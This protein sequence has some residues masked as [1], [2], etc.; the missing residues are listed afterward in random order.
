VLPCV[1]VEAVEHADAG[2]ECGGRKQ[3]ELEP[4]CASYGGDEDSGGKEDAYGKLFGEAAGE[5][6]GQRARVD[7]EHPGGEERC[8]QSVK[9]KGSRIDAVQKIDKSQSAEGD[10]GE[11]AVAVLVMEAVAGFE[12][13]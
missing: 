11:E 9:V 7:E 3:G 13:G 5:V 6:G 12:A 8:Q 1:E 10:D 2:E 4:G